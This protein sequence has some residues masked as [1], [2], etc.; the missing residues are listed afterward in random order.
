MLLLLFLTGLLN[1]VESS[2]H[3]T[4]KIIDIRSFIEKCDDLIIFFVQKSVLRAKCD[5]IITKFVNWLADPNNLGVKTTFTIALV[6]YKKSK[7]ESKIWN[8]IKYD[9]KIDLNRSWKLLFDCWL[10]IR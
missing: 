4:W 3:W 9:K 2:S 7:N 8:E 6:D 1:V 10:L 5:A